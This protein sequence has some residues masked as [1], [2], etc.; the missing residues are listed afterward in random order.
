[1]GWL[2]LLFVIFIVSVVFI[3]IFSPNMMSEEE[4]FKAK[5]KDVWGLVKL[6]Q[7]ASFGEPTL[8]LKPA[9]RSV[10]MDFHF[11]DDERVSMSLPLKLK[12]QQ[13]AKAEYLELF[14]KHNLI[15]FELKNNVTVHL[16]RQDENLGQLVAHLYREIFGASDADIVKFKVKT[17]N[18]D[19]RIF[20]ANNQNGVK[21]NDDYT[22]EAPSSR[23]KGKSV[24]KVKTNRILNAVNFLL[25]PPLIILSYKFWG[26]TGMCW[27]ALLFFS[28]FIFHNAPYTKRSLAESSVKGSLLSCILLSATLIT[29]NISFLQSI[30]SVI[31][32]FTAILSGALVLGVA[33]KSERNI[34]HKER[35]PK[36]FKFIASFWVIGGV[37][38]LLVNEW[39]RHNFDFDKWVWFFG[40]VRIEFIIAMVLIFT[41]T[42]ALYL[43][44][45]L[46]IK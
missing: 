27:A 40:F 2:I 39:A 11:L 18:S 23:Y 14:K 15:F 30:P 3:L 7:T 36:D 43:S 42:Y 34:A 8:E 1:M 35:D 41:P 17:L 25:Y 31:G 45:K 12:K 28:F 29:Q 16:N 21:F 9:R 44:R 37:G 10:L 46:K 4:E 6:C 13:Q 32:A 24:L 38:L 19:M 22:F 26:I 33:P 20:Q 5:V